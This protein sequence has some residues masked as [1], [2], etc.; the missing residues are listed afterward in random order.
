[1]NMY[2][3]KKNKIYMSKYLLKQFFFLFPALRNR[4]LEKLTNIPL[5]ITLEVTHSLRSS[6][7]LANI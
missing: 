2:S 4:G 7:E 1:M 5:Q 3:L 6:E